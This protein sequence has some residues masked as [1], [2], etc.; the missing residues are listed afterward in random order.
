MNR[1]T[2]VSPHSSPLERGSLYLPSLS[3]SETMVESCYYQEKNRTKSR[4]PLTSSSL[5]ITHPKRLLNPSPHGST[6]SSTVRPP[7]ITCSDVPLPTLTIGM[8]PPKLSNSAAKT[9]DSAISAM[10]SPLSKPGCI[11]L[12]T[13]SRR[14]DIVLKPPASHPAF[15]IWRGEPGQRTIPHVDAL[16]GEGHVEDQEVQTRMGGDNTVLYPR[17]HV[18]HTNWA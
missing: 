18:I 3:D 2:D 10:S 6:P 5:P 12:R 4:T 1:T 8:P 13:T 9:T 17:L 15:Q 7:P 16:L 14:A 11:S